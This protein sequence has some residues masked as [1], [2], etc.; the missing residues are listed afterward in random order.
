MNSA[1]GLNGTSRGLL[2]QRSDKFEVTLDL[3]HNGELNHCLAS[4]CIITTCFK[5]GQSFLQ[6]ALGLAEL[7]LS[8]DAYAQVIAEPGMGL[9]DGSWQLSDPT[10]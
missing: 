10:L 9:A 4:A 1:A 5:A 3:M 6:Q 2:N 7:S 8:P